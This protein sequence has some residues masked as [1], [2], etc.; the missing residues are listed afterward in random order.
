MESMPWHLSV[1]EV[2]V[3]PTPTRAAT[4]KRE[5]WQQGQGVVVVVVVVVVVAGVACESSCCV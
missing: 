5:C 3:V 1:V 2:S 4:M